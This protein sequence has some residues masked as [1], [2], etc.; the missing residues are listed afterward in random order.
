MTFSMQVMMNLVESIMLQKGF[1]TRSY[2]LD[3]ISL[4][5]IR[6]LNSMY[7]IVMNFKVWERQ[8]RGMKLYYIP[9]ISFEPFDKNGLEFI[10][11]I[12]PPSNQ[13][14]LILVCINYLTN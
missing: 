7:P 12:D 6:I 4:L 10:G 2:K 11:P 14:H 9:T 8:Q 1:P 5:C 13:K 3:I